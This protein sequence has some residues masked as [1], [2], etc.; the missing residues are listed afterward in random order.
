ML[1]TIPS[2][3]YLSFHCVYWICNCKYI[4]ILDGN[5][6]EIFLEILQPNEIVMVVINDDASKQLELHLLSNYDA[7]LLMIYY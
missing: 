1:F 6:L 2:T 5:D 4:A 7:Y 3:S